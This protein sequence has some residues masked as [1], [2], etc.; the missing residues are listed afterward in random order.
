MD[1]AALSIGLH[2]TQ[3]Q[4]NISLALTKKV[5]ENSKVQMEGIVNVLNTSTPVPTSHPTL[6]KTFDVRA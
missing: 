1:I 3:L 5:M 6:G 4:Q 2:H